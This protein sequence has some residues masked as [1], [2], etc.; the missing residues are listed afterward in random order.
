MTGHGPRGPIGVYGRHEYLAEKRDALDRWAGELRDI[1]TPPP[2]T[3]IR[4]P[5]LGAA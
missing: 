3:V 4:L 1:V 5:G 2:E